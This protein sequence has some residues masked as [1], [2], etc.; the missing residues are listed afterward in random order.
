[1]RISCS[2]AGALLLACLL[3]P[4]TSA[5]QAGPPLRDPALP[6]GSWSEAARET[7][8]AIG[9]GPLAR[10][11]DGVYRVGDAVIVNDD[12]KR[13]RAHVIEISDG[14]Y[15]IHYDGFAPH[16]KRPA[17]PEHLLGYQPGYKPAGSAGPTAGKPA[18]EVGHEVQINEDGR[19]RDGRVIATRAAGG[20]LR[21]HFDGRASSD[22]VWVAA[23]QL[24]HVPGGPS[25]TAPIGPGK[26]GCTT[27]RRNAS[28]GMYEFTPKGSVVLFADGRYQYLGFAQPS[29]GRFRTDPATQVV[30][31]AD[32]HL[33][34]GEA[35]PMVQRGG[36]LYLTAPRIGERWTCTLSD[37]AVA[38]K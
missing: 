28:T 35:T 33:H 19:W 2:A 4:V 14:R 8:A 29:A 24:R 23:A 5:A 32:G 26:Y 34:G 6:Y 36:R 37:E 10:P 38:P 16:W 13:Y 20:E 15:E 22:D 30:T 12:G 27:S 3:S 7:A 21:V 17:Q 9:E 31:F 25:R 1:M 11:A 18:F